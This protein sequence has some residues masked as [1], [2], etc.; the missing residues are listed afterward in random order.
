MDRRFTA[1][2]FLL[3][4]GSLAFVSC[5]VH[6]TDESDRA[7]SPGD[8]RSV[9]AA[10]AA[11]GVLPL[12]FEINEG[13]T[14]AHVK[15]L[16][17]GH[18]HTLFLTPAGAVLS[19]QH[20]RTQNRHMSQPGEERGRD[21]AERTIARMTLVD[22]RTDVR[23]RGLEALP[24][25][26]NYVRGASA[27]G[28]RLGISTYARVRYD[29]VYPGIDLDYYGNE[30]QL[31]YDFVV[32]AGADPSAIHLRFEG[33]DLS[34][35]ASGDLVGLAR[36]G[37]I[38]MR[39]PSL[40]QD[41]EGRR[42]P[43]AGSWRLAG[44]ADASFQIGEYDTSRPLVID[45]VL[46]YSTYLGGR[47]DD[48]AESIAVDARGHAYVTG[49]TVSA[50]FP[51][52]ADALQPTGPGGFNDA[53]LTKLNRTGTALEYSTYFGGT[54]S[55]A[56]SDIALD[57][58]GNV[59]I[60]GETQSPDFPTTVNSLQ[61]FAGGSDAFIAKF[62]RSGAIVYSTFL[63]GSAIDNATS[64]AVD[65]AGVV[66]VA[67]FTASTDF[68][69]TAGAIQ[70]ANA[71]R[72][73]AFVASL[74]RAGSALR[75]ATYLGTRA[76]EG[77][78]DIDIDPLGQAYIV[79][80]TRGT[81]FPTTPGALQ[82]T[83]DGLSDQAFIAKLNRTGTALRY[84]TYFGGAGNDGGFALAVDRLGFAYVAGATNSDD[85]PTT[86]GAFQ[87]AR[88]GSDDGFVLKLNRT[89]SAVRYLTYLGGA[90][91]DFV[92][93]IALDAQGGMYLTGTTSSADFPIEDAPQG[94]YGGNTDAFV[95]RLTRD[96]AS[97]V[98][99]TYM[100]GNRREDGVAI[101][102]GAARSTYVTGFTSSRNLPTTPG[103]FQIVLGG[104]RDSFIAK[105][106]TLHA[107]G[108][109]RGR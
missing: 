103:A 88:A 31:E 11:Y 66:H 89:G 8:T 48:N 39:R 108:T 94:T 80:T 2:C 12:S 68:P 19:M 95:T 56:A 7:D 45:P 69:T 38:R 33:A 50:D 22:A 65:P 109:G 49:S 29:S 98:Y 15:F 16:S 74:N 104:D 57:R 54:G 96:G 77:A 59:Y 58:H 1:T 27:H 44:A 72:F 41:L 25:K 5:A 43:V 107:E 30:G 32:Q 75:Y 71:G 105:I 78:T 84:A 52:S 26:V 18:G 24:G 28:W 64:I 13:Q 91:Q 51:T 101:A 97:A 42:V 79:G 47:G 81:D 23:V 85:L 90:G 62:D 20:I 86:A 46:S 63:G 35:D 87:P 99:S 100:G 93:D 14:D 82:N 36:G 73:D 92:S 34:L 55:D 4:A 76:D 61:P 53:F 10:R 67:G 3:L 21:I 106:A 102:V 40:Y 17:R 83:A 60:A 6:A 37:E 70:S 9:A